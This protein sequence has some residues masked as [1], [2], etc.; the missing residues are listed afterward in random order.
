MLRRR[1]FF[2]GAPTVKGGPK[3]LS[4]LRPDGKE[5]THEDWHDAESHAIGMLIYGDATDETD[6]RGRPIEQR[7]GLV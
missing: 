4:W 6:D 7:D 1:H 5:M 2:R 3:D